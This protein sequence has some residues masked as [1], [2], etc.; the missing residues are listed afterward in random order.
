MMV[1][2]IDRHRK[3]AGIGTI[4]RALRIVPS[5]YY[6]RK[7][8]ESDPEPRLPQPKADEDPRLAI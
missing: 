1:G 5:V 3:A 2:L 4:R 7:R 6:E 8:Q